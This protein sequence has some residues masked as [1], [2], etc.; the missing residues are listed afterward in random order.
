MRTLSQT[1]PCVRLLLAIAG[2]FWIASV[3]P[4]AGAVAPCHDAASRA[5]ADEVL[6]LGRACIVVVDWAG[7]ENQVSG[8]L[9][10]VTPEWLVM[11]A[12]TEWRSEQGVPMLKN[13][14]SV[15]RL[16]KNVGVARTQEDYWIPRERVVYIRAVDEF[17]EHAISDSESEAA[18][19]QTGV[20][21]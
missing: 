9:R 3:V 1:S 13:I 5:T 15:N 11:H 8:Q 12:E 10:Q 16:F 18:K 21:R 14:P 6:P 2:G 19:P 4:W 7:G 20:E 17:A